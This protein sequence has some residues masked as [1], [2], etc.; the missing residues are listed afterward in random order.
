VYATIVDLAGVNE[1][2]DGVSFLHN[3]YRL[4]G[5]NKP[6]LYFDYK[7][8][9]DEGGADTTHSIWVID[10]KYKLYDSIVSPSKFRAGR[11]YNYQK[12]P[13]EGQNAH[14][15]ATDRSSYEKYRFNS[16]KNIID[17]IKSGYNINYLVSY[18]YE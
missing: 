15:N 7:P 12:N 2:K 18:L 16:F 9:L 13:T 8:M 11:F 14:I 1:Q 6:Y 10:K 17:S 3:I 5:S 4:P